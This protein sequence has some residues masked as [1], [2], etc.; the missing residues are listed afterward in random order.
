[1]ESSSAPAPGVRPEEIERLRNDVQSRLAAIVESSDD[2]IVSKTLDGIIISW[3]KGAQRVFGWTSDEVIGKPINIIIPPDRQHE[4]PTILQNLR[5][6]ERIDHFETIRQTKDGRLINISVTISPVRDASGRIIGA[7]KI[8]RD[9]TE[10]KR[11]EQ[12]LRQAKEV[13]EQRQREL[14]DFIENATVGIHWVG[15]DGIVLWA[16]QCELELL[17]YTKDEYIGHHIAEFHVDQPVIQDMLAR[18]TRGEKLLNY[19][20]RVRCKDGSIRHLLVNSC[21]R[22]ENGQFKNTQCFTRDVT[23]LKIAEEERTQLLERERSARLDAER[24]SRLKDDFLATLS[25]EL[26]TPLNAILGYAQL[27]RAGSMSQLDQTEAVEVI[28]RNARMQTQIIEDLLDLSRIISGKIRLD[29]QRVDVAS[30]VTAALDTVRPAAEMK[31]I[32]LINVLDPLVGPV[33]GDPGRLQQVVWNLLNNAIKFTPKGGQVQ[34]AV[35]RVNSHVEIVVSDT[36]EGIKPE[37]LPHVFERFMQEDSSRTRRHGGLGIGLSIVKQ[38]VDLHGG[39]V[40]AKSPGLGQGS[41]FIVVL[42]L[43]VTNEDEQD[44]ARRFHPKSLLQPVG[45]CESVDLSGVRVL[46][47]DDEPDARQLVALILQT[48]RAEVVTAGSVDEAIA[49]LQSARPHVLVSDIGMPD[50][51]GYELIQRIRKLPAVDGGEVPAIALS[52]FARSEDRRRAMMAGFQMHVAKP[53][54]AAELIAVV[55]SMAGRVGTGH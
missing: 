24:A 23:E 17:G 19:A 54:D 43:S 13:A 40:R 50:Q 48:C 22:F 20:A 34:V 30:I 39:S 29:V 27:L 14:S 32:K 52:A 26:R 8:A 45:A 16:N 33:K 41:T 49:V 46:V 47:V 3:N 25:H 18:L 37:F 51:D 11:I 2:A 55:G 12:E 10:Q 1:V 38:L 5:R 21:G 42:P 4:E 28:E 9:I 6:G 31:G 35:E 7:S 36:G 15:A 53:V 44:L